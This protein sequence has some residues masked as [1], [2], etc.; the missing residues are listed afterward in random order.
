MLRS[1]SGQ[2]VIEYMLLLVIAIAISA[3]MVRG[4]A[5]RTEGSEGIVVKRWKQIQEEIGNDLPDKCA[6]E[7][8]SN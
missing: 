1:K 8:C 5:N 2:I 4:L 6:A 3:I 7:Q